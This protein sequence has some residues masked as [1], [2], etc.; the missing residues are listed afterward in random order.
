LKGNGKIDA[1]PFKNWKLNGILH[2]KKFG[3][4]FQARLCWCWI[5]GEE[6]IGEFLE[7]EGG[8][9]LGFRTGGG[10]EGSGG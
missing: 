2:K 3:D 9:G 8:Y 4:G 10:G 7:M 6:A 5:G 1:L